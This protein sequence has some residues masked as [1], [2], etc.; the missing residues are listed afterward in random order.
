M[1]AAVVVLIPPAI[2]KALAVLAVVEQVG[3]PEL[4]GLAAVVAVAPME[5]VE[6]AVQ[7]S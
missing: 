3:H 6:T 2:L 7:V 1:L 4:L 5:M